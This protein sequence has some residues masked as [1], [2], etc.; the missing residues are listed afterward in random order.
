MAEKMSEESVVYECM[1]CGEK[2]TKQEWERTGIFKCP[3]CGW[4]I[5]RKL[6]PPIVRRVKAV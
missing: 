3:N 5:G 6:R 4:R 2:A 1:V